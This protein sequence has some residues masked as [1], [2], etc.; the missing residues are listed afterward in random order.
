MEHV[1]EFKSSRESEI[2]RKLD[3]LSAKIVRREATDKDKIAYQELLA[4]RMRLM[5]PR[6]RFRV[7]GAGRRHVA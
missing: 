7:T 3:Q 4:A 2:D 1:V 6:F 5:R